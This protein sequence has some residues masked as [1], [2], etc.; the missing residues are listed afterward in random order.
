MGGEKILAHKF[1]DLIGKTQIDI[2]KIYETYGD[3]KT[4]TQRKFKGIL[5]DYLGV[6]TNHALSDFYYLRVQVA[7]EAVIETVNK[8]N[9]K[10]EIRDGDS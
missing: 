1:L 9:D 5:E 7:W 6:P 3:L 2:Q 10:I 8:E 4:S